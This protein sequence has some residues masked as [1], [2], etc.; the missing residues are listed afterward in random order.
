MGHGGAEAFARE[1]GLVQVHFRLGGAAGVGCEQ[2]SEVEIE[3]RVFRGLLQAIEVGLFGV[4][5]LSDRFLDG[6]EGI[7]EL[8]G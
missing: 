1:Q 3:G 6:T 4:E 5:G 7:E 8:A 2:P